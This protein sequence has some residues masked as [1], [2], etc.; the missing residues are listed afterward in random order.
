MKQY[1]M[2][3]FCFDTVLEWKGMR[4]PS[5]C[6]VFC[7]FFCVFVCLCMHVLKR[8]ADFEHLQ[9][10]TVLLALTKKQLLTNV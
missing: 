2:F 3:V 10:F 8:N 4:C 5:G 7:L 1:Y 6:L 9:S